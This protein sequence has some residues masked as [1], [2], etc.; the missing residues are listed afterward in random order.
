MNDLKKKIIKKKKKKGLEFDNR[1]PKEAFLEIRKEN[2]NL[3]PKF[4]YS[5]IFRFSETFR[6]AKEKNN[7]I[8]FRGPINS[9]TL[10]CAEEGKYNLN[11]SDKFGFKNSNDIYKKKINT[12]LLGDSFAEGDCQNIEN[13]IAGNLNKLGFRTANFGVVGTSVLVPVGIMR[14]FGPEIMPRSFIYLYD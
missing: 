4:F 2:N 3:E 6:N 9:K 5:P 13:D 7:L 14:E 8:P 1:S 11:K 12:I 10:S